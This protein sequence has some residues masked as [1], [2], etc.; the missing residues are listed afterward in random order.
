M[1]IYDDGSDKVDP[2]K[3]KEQE[4]KRDRHR[5]YSEAVRP[6]M[7][8][9]S[10]F[11]NAARAGKAT[12]KRRDELLSLIDSAGVIGEKYHVSCFGFEIGGFF[13]PDKERIRVLGA[14]QLC[15]EYK[16]KA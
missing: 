14:Y 1:T 15:V 3:A 6:V 7:A 16:R 8:E 2:Q 11:V 5:K 4:E 13:E 9:I 12:K 10:N